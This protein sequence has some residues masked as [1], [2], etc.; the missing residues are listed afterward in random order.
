MFV[1]HDRGDED[2]WARMP[3]AM[4]TRQVKAQM[5]LGGRYVFHGCIRRIDL[6]E[7][8]FSDE[9]PT[10]PVSVSVIEPTPTA[11][12]YRV[13]DVWRHDKPWI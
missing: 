5:L 10:T 9:D 1:D 3:T 12:P 8:D 7:R 4:P 6:A 13:D 11:R 2:P